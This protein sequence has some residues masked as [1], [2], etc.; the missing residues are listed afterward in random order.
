MRR[1]CGFILIIVIIAAIC[2]APGAIL[3]AKIAHSVG[4]RA[5][6][7]LGHAR[8]YSVDVT[9]GLIGLLQG[10]IQCVSINGV[11]VRL[12]NGMIVD[13]LD[14]ILDGVHFKPNQTV[15]SVE[16][17]GFSA[18]LSEANLDEFLRGTQKDMRDANVVLADDK[19]CLS[20]KPRVLAMKT[21]VRVEGTLEIVKGSKLY[22]VV[23]RL[24]ARGIRVPGFVR[25]RIMHDVNPVLDTSLMGVDAHLKSVVI[26]NG[27]IQLA[28]SADV[29]KA[30]TAH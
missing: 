8:R 22:L 30:L 5:A 20:A 19:L 25:G 2:L 26:A 14:V 3:R 15:T 11:N 29:T 16:H 18:S 7:K 27:S 1:G 17:T 28:G 21:P 4:A 12:S 24:T 13:K 23:R 9:G 10:R 6:S